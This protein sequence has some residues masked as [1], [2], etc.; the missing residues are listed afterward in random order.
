MKNKQKTENKRVA[1][2]ESLSIHSNN[3]MAQSL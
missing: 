3:L 1:S 2:S